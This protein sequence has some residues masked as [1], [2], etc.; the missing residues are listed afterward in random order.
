MST[1][2]LEKEQTTTSTVVQEK[3][4]PEHSSSAAWGPARLTKPATAVET[5]PS[6][7]DL[8]AEFMARG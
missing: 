4:Q 8:A 1:T 6:C 3:K 5:Y 7:L 2:I